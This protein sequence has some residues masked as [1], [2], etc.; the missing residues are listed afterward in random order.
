MKKKTHIEFTMWKKL[1]NMLSILLHAAGL[2]SFYHDLEGFHHVLTLIW[3]ISNMIA[4][5]LSYFLEWRLVIFLVRIKS[6]GTLCLMIQ[7]N[8]IR[9]LIY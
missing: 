4:F 3:V 5:L 8:K 7:N 1:L 6:K 9:D 2:F